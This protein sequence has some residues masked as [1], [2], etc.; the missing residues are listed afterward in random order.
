MVETKDDASY[1][2]LVASETA[3]AVTMRQAYGKEDVIPRANIRKMQS[4]SQS[5]MPEGL[6]AGLTPQELA[7]LL[8]Y[9]E[10]AEGK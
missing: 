7:D 3:N 1:I 4:Q 8:H 5:L 10:I 9:I 6:E 2:G